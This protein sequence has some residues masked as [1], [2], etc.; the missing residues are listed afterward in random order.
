MQNE[1]NISAFEKYQTT[2]KET[3]DAVAKKKKTESADREHVLMSNYPSFKV[4]NELR[5]IINKAIDS[6]EGALED[7]QLQVPP[8]HIND[9]FAFETFSL[10]K[11]LKI[12]PQVLSTKIVEGINNTA[13]LEFLDKAIPAGPFVNIDVKKTE[14]YSLIISGIY[15]LD[16]KYG[17]SDVNKGK[18]MVIDFSSPNI[19][20]PIGVGHLRSTIIGQALSNIYCK[21]GYTVIN[22]NHLGDW[23]T[24]FGKLLLAYRQWGDEEKIKESP[25]NELKNL[26]VKFH[27]LA[28]DNP[29]MEDEARAL[30]AK[31]ENGDSE[32]ITTWNKFRDLSVI[33]FDKMYKRLGIHF[34]TYIGESFFVKD[35]EVAVN[36]CLTRGFCHVD[37]E[38]GAVVVD[39]DGDLPSFLLRKQDGSTLYMSRDLA[40]VKFRVETFNPDSILYVVGSEQELNFKQLFSLASKTGYLPESVTAKHIGFGMVTVG[41]KKMSTRKGTLIELEDLLTQSVEKSRAI[42]VQKN[43]NLTQEELAEIS[44][45]VGV[46]AIIYNDLRQTRSKNI[47]FDWNKMLDFE[48]T[49]SAAYLQYTY[50]RIQ[51]I[52]RKLEET[53]PVNIKLEDN[54]IIFEAPSEFELAKKMMLFP[55]V[56]NK[57]Q[58][59]D[60][61]HIISTYLEE[62]ALTFNSFY[63]EISLMKTEAE[64]LRTSR[65]M[66]CE[67]TAKIIKDGLALLS[68]RVPQKM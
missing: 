25:I 22:D 2:V 38:T 10:A 58:K 60:S 56:I 36:D 40:A 9:D 13:T 49:G 26:Y 7:F 23:G 66:L 68:I 30:F 51:S 32:L 11:K 41:G 8:S 45:I 18:L 21:T 63:N 12:S 42:L 35:A 44:E 20:K 65:A 50:V 39:E 29:D 67:S 4:E 27:S 33:D 31:L 43:P 47:S 1:T 28:K 64:N 57:A 52:L 15:K 55:G 48:G 62:L 54:Q 5:G 24:Q 16:G 59:T 61:P 17:E 14:L 46:G 34:D 3:I 37:K 19:A 6:P 53:Y